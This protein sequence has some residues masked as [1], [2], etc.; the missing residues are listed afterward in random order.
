MTLNVVT[1]GLTFVQAT[2]STQWTINHTLGY[3]PLVNVIVNYGGVEQ[4]ILPQA[5]QQ[6]SISQV[7]ITF[8]E[9]MSGFARLS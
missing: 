1:Q 6:A 5:V 3:Y 8:S 2:P 9:P 7:I 4:Q